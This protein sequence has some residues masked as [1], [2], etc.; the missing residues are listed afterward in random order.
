MTFDNIAEYWLAET[1]SE[2]LAL[3]RRFCNL[4]TL[5]DPYVLSTPHNDHTASD[6]ADIYRGLMALIGHFAGTHSP[7]DPN[8]RPSLWHHDFRFANILLGPETF[9]V[10]GLIDWESASIVPRVLCARYQ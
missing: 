4:L 1:E 10:K 7:K 3:K 6:L 9:E 5:D 2:F 8:Y